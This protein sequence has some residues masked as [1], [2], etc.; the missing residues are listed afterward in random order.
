MPKKPSKIKVPAKKKPTP[1]KQALK[2]ILG[3]Y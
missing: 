2:K 1:R 3:S